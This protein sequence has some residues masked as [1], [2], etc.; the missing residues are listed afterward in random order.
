[1]ICCMRIKQCSLTISTALQVVKAAIL[2]SN[3]AV[4]PWQVQLLLWLKL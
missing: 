1:M 4:Q 2:S 3:L